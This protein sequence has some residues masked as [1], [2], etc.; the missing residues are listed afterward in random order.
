MKKGEKTLG[1]VL[2]LI[3]L[4]SWGLLSV[5]SLL[6]QRTNKASEPQVSPTAFVSTRPSTGWRYFGATDPMSG[7]KE[8]GAST[9][10]LNILNFDRPYQGDQRATLT[11]RK[12]P[13]FG[14]NVILQ[15]E[16]GQFLVGPAGVQVAVRF[17]QGPLI[18]FGA[19]AQVDHNT[20][21]LFIGS[22]EKFVESLRK[23]KLV[24][25]AAPV[26]QEGSPVLEF[27]VAGFEPDRGIN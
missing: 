1:A 14:N 7:I 23:A 13:R 26:Y 27:N 18:N 6:P 20:T 25:I 16:R 11:L 3:P 4:L 24:R 22:Y 19:D 2:L 8:W 9:E 12:H 21:T 15:L 10:S 5:L 17:D